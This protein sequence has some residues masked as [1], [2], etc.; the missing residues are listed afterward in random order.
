MVHPVTGWQ[1]FGVVSV[2][3][4]FQIKD[5][6]RFMIDNIFSYFLDVLLNKTFCLDKAHIYLVGRII[7]P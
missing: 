6:I 3:H 7:I 5:P 2:L 1:S 4:I